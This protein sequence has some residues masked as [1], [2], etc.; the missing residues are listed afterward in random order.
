MDRN[1]FIRMASRIALSLV[2]EQKIPVI[3]YAFPHNAS[4]EMNPLMLL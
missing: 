2:V 1:C 3:L 4:A